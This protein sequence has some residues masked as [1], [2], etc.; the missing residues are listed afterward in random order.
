MAKNVKQ[1][2]QLGQGRTPSEYKIDP[3]RLGLTGASAGGHLASLVAV[4]ADDKTAVKAVGVFF[5]PTDFL[6]Y[7]GQKID[8][9]TPPAIEQIATAQRVRLARAARPVSGSE[10][11]EEADRDQPRAAG[12]RQGPAVFDHP[13]RRRPAGAPGAIGEA[14][15]RPEG[16]R[17]AGRADRQ[18]RRRRIPGRRFTKKCR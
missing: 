3:D 11:V 17:R 2:D 18:E 8:V 7:R 12:R 15:G 13:R 14:A 6:D 4:T 16:R 9:S 1:G 5:P 10:L